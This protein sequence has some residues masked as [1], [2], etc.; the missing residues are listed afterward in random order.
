MNHNKL[1]H[2]LEEAHREFVQIN[3]IKNDAIAPAL[4]Y[5]TKKNKELV[6]FICAI[7]AYGKVD[8]IKKSVFKI[9]K[10]M[11]K[12]PLKWLKDTTPNTIYKT[13][14]GWKHRFNNHQDLYDLLVL[15]RHIYLKSES[16]EKYFK[17]KKSESA[18]LFLNRF[19][20]GF[21]DL[22][23]RVKPKIHKKKSFKYL[24]P[25]PS[26]GSACKRLNLYLRWMVRESEM[27]LNLWN[28][29]DKKN[30]VIPL[31]TH[32]MRQSIKLGITNRKTASWK[33][34]LDI[35]NFLKKLD[36]LDPTRFDFA[37]CHIGI[38]KKTLLS[39]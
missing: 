7:F 3:E 14:K 35:T 31:D 33:T 12:N 11:G 39:I 30:L 2:Y 18:F 27:D 28:S 10:P 36:P 13:Y 22:N 5:K 21:L 1:K 25:K 9:L 38:T 26:N 23:P 4:K 29:F 8:Q 24:F 32:V 16:I 34:A 17:P 19:M 20:D 6:A 37:I 15:L